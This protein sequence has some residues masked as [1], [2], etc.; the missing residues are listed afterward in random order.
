MDKNTAQPFRRRKFAHRAL[1]GLAGLQ[2]CLLAHAQQSP[3][4]AE[5]KAPDYTVTGNGYLLSTGRTRVFVSVA[6]N[7]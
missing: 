5:A 2:F 6:R 1:A 7:F 4:P 3:Q